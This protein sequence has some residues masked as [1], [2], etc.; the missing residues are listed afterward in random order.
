MPQAKITTDFIYNND[1]IIDGPRSGEERLVYQ[2]LFRAVMDCLA[3]DITV[4]IVDKKSA[5]AWITRRTKK[6]FSFLWCCDLLDRDG[7]RLIRYLNDQ[8]L[9]KKIR[10]KRVE[11]KLSWC[12]RQERKL[13]MWNGGKSI[14]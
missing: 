5:L 8:G 13:K 12:Q 2:V 10:G 14:N 9:I 4:D 1:C 11:T 3:S 7:G 6:D